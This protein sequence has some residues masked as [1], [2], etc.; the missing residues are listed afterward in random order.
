VLPEGA[1]QPSFPVIPSLSRAFLVGAQP[2][3]QNPQQEER[4]AQQV[5][6]PEPC[7]L[8]KWAR[9]P[10]EPVVGKQP[11]S[12]A[13]PAGKVVEDGAAGERDIG[14]Y[15]IP[16]IHQPTFLPRHPKAHHQYLR[17]GSVDLLYNALVLWA[18]GGVIEI[19]VMNPGYLQGG[20][21]LRKPP[22]GL[23]ADASRASAQKV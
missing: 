11:W 21:P 15:P 8:H 23:L 16:V 12:P 5:A 1:S 4:A 3:P 6:P 14:V 18:S 9:Q 17:F 20:E 22:R 13:Q 10:L 2:L 19:A 7:G